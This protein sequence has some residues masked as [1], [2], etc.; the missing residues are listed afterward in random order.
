MLFFSRILNFY[1]HE[2]A[3]LSEIFSAFFFFLQVNVN[4]SDDHCLFG[5]PLIRFFSH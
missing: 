3:L 2:S 5:I 1:L 4:L